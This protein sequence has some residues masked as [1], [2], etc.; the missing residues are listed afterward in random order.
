MSVAPSGQT[1]QLM[2]SS[3]LKPWRHSPPSGGQFVQKAHEIKS[4][5]SKVIDSGNFCGSVRQALVNTRLRM[6]S[7]DICQEVMSLLKEVAW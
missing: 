7:D 6:A 1:L 3:L 2:E 5:D 4:E